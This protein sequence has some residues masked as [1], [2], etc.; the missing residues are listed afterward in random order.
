MHK[1][2]GRSNWSPEVAR[3]LILRYSKEGDVL[4]NPMISG[5]TTVIEVKL[6]YIWCGCTRCSVGLAGSGV[7]QLDGNGALAERLRRGL[8]N[9]VDGFD[10][11]RCLHVGIHSRLRGYLVIKWLNSSRSL[12]YSS[13]QIENRE[14]FQFQ[15][16]SNNYI[17]MRGWW[18]R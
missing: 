9:L 10:S 13:L 16:R 11:R 12:R 1:A 15:G 14:C 7:L 4:L 18:N 17:Y 8:Q 3:N 2:D 6:Q 5:D